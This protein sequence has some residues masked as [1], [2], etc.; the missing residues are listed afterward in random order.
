MGFFARRRAALT[1][2]VTRAVLEAVEKR[3]DERSKPRIDEVGDVAA[4]MLGSMTGFLS[5]AG[6]LALRGAASALGQRGGRRTQD[7]RRQLKRLPAGTPAACELCRDPY[8]RNLTVE[9]IAR[10]RAHEGTRNANAETAQQLQPDEAEPQRDPV[11]G[12]WPGQ[13]IGW[14]GATG[15]GNQP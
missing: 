7:K 1:E 14:N 6:D 11:T 13:A 9:M 2:A 5:G 12:L 10:H 4:K 8:T 15:N 3:L